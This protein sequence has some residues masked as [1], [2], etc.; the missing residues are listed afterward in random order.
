M[1]NIFNELKRTQNPIIGLYFFFG[2]LFSHPQD[3]K[4]AWK[5]QNDYICLP[6]EGKVH[7]MGMILVMYHANRCYFGHLLPDI[8]VFA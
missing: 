1:F 4:S 3:P 6:S 5:R 7:E 8:F 2:V